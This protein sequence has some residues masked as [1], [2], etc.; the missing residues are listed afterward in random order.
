M[1][2]SGPPNYCYWCACV[3]FWADPIESIPINDGDE[4]T[5]ILDPYFEL[6]EWD[7]G[8]NQFTRVIG[9][10]TYPP[11]QIDF[12]IADLDFELVGSNSYDVTLTVGYGHFGSV[13]DIALPYSMLLNGIPVVSDSIQFSFEVPHPCEESYPGCMEECDSDTYCRRVDLGH[14]TWESFC[15]CNKYVWVELISAYDLYDG[16]EINIILDPDDEVA[17]WD[18]ANNEIMITMG[19]AVLPDEPI[20]FEPTEMVF[21]PESGSMYT[22]Q[23]I[24]K[25]S[26]LIPISPPS[27]PCS[28]YV[29][30]I[31]VGFGPIGLDNVSPGPCNDQATFPGCWEDCENAGC[32][33]YIFR[34]WP[35]IIWAMFCSCAAW[36]PFD[37]DPVG[38]GEG[39]IVSV[40]IDPFNEFDEWDETNNILNTSFT[41]T[42]VT[43][44]RFFTAKSFPNPFNPNIQIFYQMPATGNLA[45]KIY[46]VRGRLVRTLVDQVVTAGGTKLVW[47]GRDSR[48]REVSSGVYFWVARA[49]GETIIDKVALI[50]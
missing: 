28:L 46:D 20:D 23:L 38:I 5:V 16:D 45:I 26:T 35:G 22:V 8:N 44:P 3:T 13:G 14:P 42:S 39:D 21:I 43:E 36:T 27:V 48:G 15:K 49:F 12:E 31:G 47:N 11:E 29:N 17:E 19:Q 34:M 2:T 6:D 25:Y 18:E 32:D 33:L 4:L 24:T 37:F 10:P 7:E 1:V 30:N 41:I 9:Q 50:K 40:K